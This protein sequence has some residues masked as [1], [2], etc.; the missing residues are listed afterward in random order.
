MMKVINKPEI[1][2]SMELGDCPGFFMWMQ[3]RFYISCPKIK[4]KKKSPLGFT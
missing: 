4:N 2:F 1:Y 3:L